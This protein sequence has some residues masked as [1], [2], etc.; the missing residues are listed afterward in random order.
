[1]KIQRDLTFIPDIVRLYSEWFG[2]KFTLDPNPPC[3]WNIPNQSMIW[4]CACS[5]FCNMNIFFYINCPTYNY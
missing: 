1:M 3:S 5:L 4:T 2:H